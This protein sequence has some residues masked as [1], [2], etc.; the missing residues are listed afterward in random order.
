[1][2][3][4]YSECGENASAHLQGESLRRS[5]LHTERKHLPALKGRGQFAFND[6]RR[7]DVRFDMGSPNGLL[8]GPRQL[9]L[10]ACGFASQISKAHNDAEIR[11]FLRRGRGH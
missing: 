4:C 5:R 2:L 7:Y 8:D 10:A 3:S 9:K 1:M 6:L 11:T